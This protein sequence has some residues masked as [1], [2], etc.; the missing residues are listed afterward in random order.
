MAT[1]NVVDTLYE[2]DGTTTFTGPIFISWPTFQSTADSKQHPAGVLPY[3]VV[4]GVLNVNLEPTDATTPSGVYYTVVYRLIS[5][6][7]TT[8]YWLVPTSG[9]PVNLATIRSVP[10]P[11][12]SFAIS[13]AQLPATTVFT[14]QANTFGAFIQKVKD[15]TNFEITNA[16]DVTKI[17]KFDAS[18]I[19]T[20]TTRT[21]TI[22]DNDS[23]LVPSYAT[24]T[25]TP[26]D[27]SGA[28]LVFTGASGIYIKIGTLVFVTGTATYP[29]TANGT[30]AKIG[31][32][33]FTTNAVRSLGTATSSSGFA[34]TVISTQIS[35]TTFNFLNA[36]QVQPTNA[37]FSTSTF[38]TS[39]TYST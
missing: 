6:T 24:G 16:A 18:A 37:Q 32:L 29:A 21:I 7:V 14:D 4:S 23:T 20:A 3:Q 22:P 10:Q 30:S 26:I 31:G 9:S 28:G 36:T 19:T 11:P 17:T 33:P 25:W 34:A 5:G 8:E 13:K 27:S 35:A 2:A 1:T 15:G 38:F 12:I 39:L